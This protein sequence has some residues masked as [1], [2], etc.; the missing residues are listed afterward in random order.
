[1]EKLLKYFIAPTLTIIILGIAVYFFFKSIIVTS[2]PKYEGQVEIHG[3]TENVEI[4]TNEH[5]IPLIKANNRKDLVFALGYLHA[6]DRLLEMEY[7]K[8]IATGRLSEIFGEKTL[9][10][11]KLFRQF[12]LT[13]KATLFYSQLDT[14]SKVMIKAYSDGINGYLESDNPVFQS[15]FAALG[16]APGKWN[17]A[18][19]VLLTLLNNFDDE[20]KLVSKKMI[21]ILRDKLDYA[22]S[23]VVF[24]GN[25]D[26]IARDPYLK[27]EEELLRN[28]IGIRILTQ[29]KSEN[30]VSVS[31]IKGVEG[32]FASVNGRFTFPGRYYQIFFES[33]GYSGGGL[34]IPGV[35]LLF[36]GMKKDE[37]WALNTVAK[38]L[39]KR[40]NLYL[41]DKGNIFNENKSQG[42]IKI[43]KDTILVK[44]RDPVFFEIKRS[45][46][47]GAVISLPGKKE[48][49][50]RDSTEI[51]NLFPVIA[52]DQ[53]RFDATEFLTTGL[54]LWS[55]PVA[56]K[57]FSTDAN[58]DII[59]KTGDKPVSKNFAKV[60]IKEKKE[61]TAPKGKKTP[62]KKE[63]AK[64]KPAREPEETDTPE[65]D[66]FTVNDHSK[67]TDGEFFEIL[68]EFKDR[69]Y[70]LKHENK[71]I[72]SYFLND[73]TSDFSLKMV[74]FILNAFTNEDKKDTILQQSL[75]VLSRWSGEYQSSLQAPLIFATFMK[76]FTVNTF[77]DDL[78]KNDF[79]L[80]FSWGGIP[81][82]RFNKLI[83]ENYSPVFD[84]RNSRE[85][86]SRD[87]MI[88]RS[89]R[90]SL[91]ELRNKYDDNLIMWLWGKDNIVR[92]SHIIASF[93]GGINNAIALEPAGISGY[94][95]TRFRVKSNPFAELLSGR[96]I[97]VSG[98]L[99]RFYIDLEK[100]QMSF[101]P[102]LG[103]SGNFADKMSVIN[104][105]NFLEGKLLD[106]TVKSSKNDKVLI[107]LKKM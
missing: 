93:L 102:Y 25:I 48:V 23:A 1:M 72:P 85:V 22:S 61:G 44:D 45:P 64:E 66:E 38:D 42:A 4:R 18:D 36:V 71:N 35:P 2:V 24:G 103:N 57:S 82:A 49:Y 97:P 52:V 81:F 10:S 73:V 50:N 51:Y 94:S 29:L 86:E 100:G 80:L 98:T 5:G 88:R 90:A 46:N 31:E 41:D 77:G 20:S 54:K 9:E 68:P 101:V 84:N 62:K 21:N 105:L 14:E 76:F 91:D 30:S 3:L 56:S 79:Q 15:E 13:S 75:K 92:P 7:H 40:N 99:F 58:T 70:L 74:P 60:V 43:D 78:D 96:N 8:L 106:G 6:R 12:D 83:E 33:E 69:S 16:F 19:I 11:D 39:P 104:Y 89:F 17:P 28:E 32:V 27:E 37:F 67:L 34:T 53:S 65:S 63:T 26:T 87:E 47:G 55:E 59:Y 107:L 95:D